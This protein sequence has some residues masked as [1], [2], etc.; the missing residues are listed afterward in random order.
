MHRS[1]GKLSGVLH[2]GFK[3]DKCKTSLRM[4]VARI[5]L[6]RNRKEAQVRQMRREVAQLLEANQ[7]MT[8]RIRVEHVIREEKFMQAYDLLE[9]YCELIVARLSIIDSQKACPIDLKEAIASVIF[10]SMRCSDVT[11]LAD[12]RK[13]FTSKYGKEF[14]TAALEARPDSGVNRLVIEKLSAG[15]PDIQTKIKTLT[16]IAEE[17]NIKWVPKAFEEKL[18][19]PNED[20]LY[21]PATYSGGNISTMGSSTSSMSAPQ[22]TYSGVPA[23]TVEGPYS[24]ADVSANRNSNA[25]SQENIRSGSSA[26]VPPSSQH[27]ASASYSAQIPGPNSISHGN[28][29]DP[30]YPQYGATVPDTV[31]RNEEMN[32]H[33]ERKPSVSGANWNVEF[34]DATS[35]AQAAAES[36]EMASIAAR[37]AAQLASRGNYSGGQSTGDYEA[38]AY[39]HE[40]TPRKQPAEHLVK[41]ENRSFHDQSS[42]I[43]DPRAMPYARKRS[44]RAETN[45]VENQ[46]ISTV[47]APAQS[48]KMP[49]V[50]SPAQQFH[51]YSRESHVYEMPTEQ[52]HA[53]SPEPPHFDD[54]YERESNIGRSEVH[55][56][57]LPSGKLQETEPAGRNVQD[58]KPSFDQESTNDYYGNFNSSQDTFTYGSSS[59]WDQQNDKTRDS[60]SVAFDQYDSDVEE[61]NLLDTFSSK[62]TEQPPAVQDHMGFTTADWSQQHRSESPNHRTSMLFSRTETQ[63]SDNLGANRSDVHSPRPYDSLPPTFDSDGSSSDE[64]IGTTMR[65]E[66]LKSASGLNKEANRISGKV[67]PDVKESIGD[68]EPSS[69]KKFMASPGLNLSYKERH[70]GGTGGSPISDYLGGQAPGHFNHVQSRDSDLSDEETELD[71]FKSAFSPEANENQSLPFAIRTSATSDDKEGDLGLNFG[72]LTPGLRNKPRQPPPYTK[73]SRDNILPSQSLPKA[74]ASTEESVDSEENTTSF[75]QNRSSPKSSLSTRT[76]SGGNYNSEL[77]DRNRIIG[78]HG[79]ARSTM[80]TNFFDSD[81]TEKLSKQSIN[82]SSPTTKSSERVNSNQEL[83]HEKPGTGA[84]REMRSRM[85][86]HY[87][88]SE[89]SEEELEPQQTTQPKRSGVQIQ[90]RRTRDVTSDTKRDGHVRTGARYAEET[91][92]LTKESNAPQ[93][94]NSSAEQRRVAAQ[95]SSPEDERV[96]SPMGA[97]GKS[98]EAEISRSSVPGNVR[99]S[100]T[101]GETLKESTPKTPPAHVHPKLPTD[102]D[103]FAAHFMSLRTNR[104]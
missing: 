7:D 14:A 15:A 39:S 27:D 33:R 97:R 10:A 13:Q 64:E 28:T 84:C 98:Q 70:S 30:P 62:Q 75:V 92:S 25:F 22:P 91:E 51:S 12:V 100:E 69:S 60:S 40:N 57:D 21:G 42:G 45:H 104:R 38:A 83:Y 78:T 34:K 81:D 3:P 46:N 41:D 96:E 86:R 20:H 80:A 37:A 65:T 26:S 44:G 88:D 35:A 50:H 73:I 89:D 66:S 1:K 23:A 76:S 32:R 16:S 94:N 102:Y 4:A 5:K 43:N 31:S 11:E 77:Y 93:L 49:T 19:K 82:P 47:H 79:E 17:H 90:S 74:S 87:F 9:V 58:R 68:Y 52:P 101:S 99:N 59:V 54:L 18:Q 24:P 8:A 2:K 36:A 103:S 29:G 55:P 53:H 72:K 71:K 67:V 48:Q 6:L 95:R 56:F 61:E 85:A 63:Q